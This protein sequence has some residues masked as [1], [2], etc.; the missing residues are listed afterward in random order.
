MSPAAN[1]GYTA[2]NAYS[3]EAY[4]YENEGEEDTINRQQEIS[5]REIN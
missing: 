2:D 3:A 1:H 4:E 5:V